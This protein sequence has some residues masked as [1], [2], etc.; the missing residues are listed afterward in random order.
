MNEATEITLLTQAE[1][2][3]CDHAKEVLRRVSADHPLQV[4]E[5]DLGSDEGHELALRAGVVF[6][7]G[8]LLDGQPFSFGRLSE[9]KLRRALASRRT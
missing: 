9:R 3:F 7:P 6:A 1:C 2:G 8:V 5:V 4:C